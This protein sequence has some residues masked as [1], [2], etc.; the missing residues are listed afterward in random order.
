MLGVETDRVRSVPG[1]EW[2]VSPYLSILQAKLANGSFQQMQTVG[3][4]TATL[5]GRPARM[6]EGTA[7]D[8]RTLHKYTYAANDPVNNI[9][10]TGHDTTGIL[11]GIAVAVVVL[12]IASV[13]LSYAMRSVK[14][15]VG[16]INLR[17]GTNTGDPVMDATIAESPHFVNTLGSRPKDDPCRRLFDGARYA[18]GTVN[19]SSRNMDGDVNASTE[20]KLGEGFSLETASVELNPRR[21]DYITKAVI[22]HELLHVTGVIGPDILTSVS[23][24]GE[25]VGYSPQVTEYVRKKCGFQ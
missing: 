10:P 23:I 12:A 3:L 20:S 7:D 6:I 15:Q 13:V 21:R 9:D 4:D 16:G 19:F 25:P 5:V 11:I 22:V 8:P 2:A 18:R 1:V 24:N 14:D 17:V